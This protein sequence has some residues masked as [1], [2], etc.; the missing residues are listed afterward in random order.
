MPPPGARSHLSFNEQVEASWALLA[1]NLGHCRSHWTGPRGGGVGLQGSRPISPT[2]ALPPPPPHPRTPDLGR[3]RAP[4]T[5]RLQIS[6]RLPPR[7]GRS[8]RSPPS[9]EGG[10]EP[11]PPHRPDASPGPPRGPARAARAPLGSA[12]GP[13]PPAPCSGMDQQR[14]QNF[15]M[16]RGAGN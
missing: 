13:L 5:R 7:V 9:A 3:Q 15:F 8:P 10:S 6:L 1:G 14:V 4:G 12:P 16:A 11:A 2:S